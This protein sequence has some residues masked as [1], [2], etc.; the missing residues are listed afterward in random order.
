MWLYKA[1]DNQR[2]LSYVIDNADL[3]GGIGWSITE[4]SWDVK[5]AGIQVLA[6]QVRLQHDHIA[7]EHMYGLFVDFDFDVNVLSC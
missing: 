2:Y 6:S 3:F 4:F 1:T 5:Y 7:H